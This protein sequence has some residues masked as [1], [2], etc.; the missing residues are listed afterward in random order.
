MKQI[1]KEDI[2]KIYKEEKS[3]LKDGIKNGKNPYHIFSL[4]TINNDF[5]DS[6]MIVLRNIKFS[7]FKIYF[8]IDSR[9][10]KAKQLAMK[11]NCTAL[12]Y[13][14]QRR[15]QIRCKCMANIHNNNSISKDIWEQ[16]AL[17]S[18][19]CYMGA[20]E[21]SIILDSWH[22][23]IP[24]KYLDKDPEVQDSEQGYKNFSHI[25]LT[26]IELDI[27]QL[28]Y[29]GHIRFKVNSQDQIN[30]ISP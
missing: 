10:P 23:N 2:L 8:N 17:Q 26:M 6:R 7:P 21:P 9:S 1:N 24:E 3:F 11:N 19:K 5:S 15:V 30:F 29:N 25:E 14:S 28:H 20:Y 12:F 22:P 4:S 13:D 16:T 18:R 27:L